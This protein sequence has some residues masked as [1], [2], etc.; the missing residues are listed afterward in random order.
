[1]RKDSTRKHETRHE[2]GGVAETSKIDIK[3][4]CA[5]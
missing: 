1:L 4:V 5:S 2:G 3:P